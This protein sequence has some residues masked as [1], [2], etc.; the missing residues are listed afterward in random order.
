MFFFLNS[1]LIQSSQLQPLLPS[2]QSPLTSPLT[3]IHCSC[4]SFQKRTRYQ[5]NTAYQDAIRQGIDPGRLPSPQTSILFHLLNVPTP[6][7][8]VPSLPTCSVQ[9]GRDS[10][11]TKDQADWE[12]LRWAA[13][14]PNFLHSKGLCPPSIPS[15]PPS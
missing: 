3:Q 13:C 11:Y 1:S 7:P 5:V 6:F 8:P 4:I 14:V 9:Q 12:K 15:P 10:H 2:S